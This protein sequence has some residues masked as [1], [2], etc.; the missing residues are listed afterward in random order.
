MH[1]GRP[2]INRS[3]FPILISVSVT[4][5]PTGSIRTIASMHSIRSDTSNGSRSMV[6][7][8]PLSSLP[9]IDNCNST[10]S[11]LSRHPPIVSS[12]HTRTVDDT[13]VQNQVYV[14]P[15]DPRV[16]TPSRGRC[17]GS[18]TDLDEEIR[19]AIDRARGTSGGFLGASP[20]TISSG[21]SLR[22]NIF[23][24]P[25]PTMTNRTEIII[26]RLSWFFRRRLAKR[27]THDARSS[28][29]V[30]SE[31]ST[32]VSPMSEGRSA[33]RSSMSLR[34]NKDMFS[35]QGVLEFQEIAMGGYYTNQ[36]SG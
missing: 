18:M 8:P 17:S 4:R 30:S 24:T 29:F 1:I 10:F 21:S 14:Y 28:N 6:F 33:I 5:S 2:S 25:P 16:I 11:G 27:T 22:R 36:F 32:P 31:T 23:V 34:G 35:L 3:L 20:I 19:S 15:G 9:D 7:I 12:H 26:G 13:V